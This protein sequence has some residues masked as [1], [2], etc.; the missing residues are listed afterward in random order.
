MGIAL[1]YFNVV[2]AHPSGEMGEDSGE[3]PTNLLPNL[4]RVVTGKQPVLKIFGGDYA[5]VDGTAVRDYVHVCDIADGHL[6]ALQRIDETSKKLENRE[7]SREQVDKE[8]GDSQEINGGRV[9]KV[10]E[11]D[12][13]TDEKIIQQLE[14]GSSGGD[15]QSKIQD[16]IE[17]IEGKDE[18]IEND[19]NLEDE[20]DEDTYLEEKVEAAIESQ[21]QNYLSQEFLLSQNEE[22][23]NSFEAPKDMGD[24]G[25]T[26]D[27]T[28]SNFETFNLGIGKGVSV[29]EI[30]SAFEEAW[31]K[32]INYEIV[33]RQEG[34][35]EEIVANCEKAE[36]V[37]GFKAKRGIK[38][39][40]E[41][42]AKWT[43]QFPNGF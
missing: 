35:A 12:I 32:K 31:G 3:G 41:S 37:L 38:E 7:Q 26:S 23:E 22:R 42:V 14:E 21:I 4:Q 11:A 39:I 24:Q 25:N 18:S 15:Q 2:G 8:S 27:L 16:E 5:T 33:E 17:E 1:R 19:E 9:Q 30:T 6:L 36:K 13:D 34:D 10:N 28:P 20:Q 43:N 40:C 29:L